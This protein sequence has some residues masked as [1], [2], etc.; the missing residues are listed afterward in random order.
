RL[1]PRSLRASVEYRSSH[2]R[3]LD[4][5]NAVSLHADARSQVSV[6]II[7]ATT[8]LVAQSMVA[9]IALR[10]ALRHPHLVS[11]LVLVAAITYPNAKSCYQCWPVGIETRLAPTAGWYPLTRASPRPLA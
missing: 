4:G 3:C 1:Y 10:I 11:H 5:R 2:R 6:P 8:A 9:Y 7:A